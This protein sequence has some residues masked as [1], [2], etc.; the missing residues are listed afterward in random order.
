M[1]YVVNY[2]R[3]LNRIKILIFLTCSLTSQNCPLFLRAFILA[4]VESRNVS[5]SKIKYPFGVIF[6]VLGGK[7]SVTEVEGKK[8]KK[9]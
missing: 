1:N 6:E 3:D 2:G 8:K 5:S 4:T 9:L 7:P